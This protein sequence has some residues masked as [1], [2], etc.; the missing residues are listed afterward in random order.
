[1]SHWYEKNG[2]PKYTIV[3]ANGKERDTTLRDA[4]KLNLFPSTTTVLNELSAPGLERWKIDQAMQAVLTLPRN[5]GESLD[6]FK[7]RA[8]I[9]SGEQARKARER[10]E[11]RLRKGTDVDWDRARVSLEKAITRLQV[12]GKS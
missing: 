1:M 6:E 4:R 2:K 9:D 8:L 12:A 10:A 5:A 3:G 11:E 7:R